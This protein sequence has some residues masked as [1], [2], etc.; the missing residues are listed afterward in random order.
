MRRVLG[1]QMVAQSCAALVECLLNGGG[2]FDG[3][4]GAHRFKSLVGSQQAKID[5][6]STVSAKFC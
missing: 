5:K 3:N 1:A 2:K 4:E 6:A